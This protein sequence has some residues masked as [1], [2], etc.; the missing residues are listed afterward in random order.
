[1]GLLAPLALAFVPLLGLI[2]ALYLL[3]LRRPETAVSSL[4]LWESLAAV[5][6]G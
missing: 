3:R 1:M 5:P 6:G 4:Y 2:L